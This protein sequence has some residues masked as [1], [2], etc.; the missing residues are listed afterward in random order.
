M[1]SG[2]LSAIAMLVPGF[3]FLACAAAQAQEGAIVSLL[4]ETPR[5]ARPPAPGSHLPDA[6][7]ARD[8]ATVH[9]C[10]QWLEG[11]APALL[12]SHGAYLEVRA[13]DSFRV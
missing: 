1:T 13:L 12:L 3:T 7:A 8:H 11:P 2:R 9:G 6:S 4:T 10:P 5:T